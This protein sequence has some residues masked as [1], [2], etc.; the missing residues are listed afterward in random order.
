MV[1]GVDGGAG[2]NGVARIKGGRKYQTITRI[3]VL[4][5]Y[6]NNAISKKY[7]TIYKFFGQKKTHI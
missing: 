7:E 5:R 1:G 3:F 2:R 6:G 4:G